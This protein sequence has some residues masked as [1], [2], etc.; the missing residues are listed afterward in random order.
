MHILHILIIVTVFI[1]GQCI[2]LD[3]VQLKT[4]HKLIQS[5]TI[6]PTQRVILNNV[7]YNAYEKMA[8]KKAV[9]FKRMHT[10]KCAN[11][12]IEE[13]VC[14]SKMGLFKAIQ[15]YNG[16]YSFTCFST[17]YINSELYNVVTDK[18]ALSI[19]PK[20]IR[21]KTKS[22]FTPNENLKYKSMLDVKLTVL[23]ESWQTEQLFQSAEDVMATTIAKYGNVDALYQE[24][25]RLPAFTK[26]I[27]YLRYIM[28][29][30]Q[31]VSYKHMAQLMC[32][33]EEK[34]R[35]EYIKIKQSE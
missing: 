14:S 17:I 22:H 4:I 30:H 6:Q 2:H 34:I 33:S 35:Q 20:R 24:M 16:K 21:C 8:V 9:N 25:D 27:V 7:L 19:L 31:K 13:L 26:R 15:K 29:P 1:V 12:K 32:C 3:N 5:P 28:Y 23:Y 10:H 11:I 18:Y